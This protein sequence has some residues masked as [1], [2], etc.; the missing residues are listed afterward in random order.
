MR[1]LLSLAL[2]APLLQDPAPLLW[3]PLK[4][5]SAPCCEDPVRNELKKIDAIKS[6]SV[7][8]RGDS[9]WAGINLKPG[10]TL[11]TTSVE[12]A[13]AK[14]TEG[15]GKM[16]GTTYEISPNLSAA[17]VWEYR[18]EA[19]PDEAKLKEAL[20]KFEASVTV[21]KTG[22][23]AVFAKEPPSAADVRAAAGVKVTDVLLAASKD[24]ARY[25]CAKHPD[26]V[27]ALPG[28][29]PGCGKALEKVPAN[30]APTPPADSG[31]HHKKGH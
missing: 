29:C 10:L 18:T 31:K 2:L 21:S 30:P 5:L 17:L 23:R 3:M 1:L 11:K 25:T 28:A 8:K 4:G 12:K 15:M 26:V 9:Y 24:G 16:M 27:N 20:A 6:V 7:E 22:F 13:L 19:P 14:A